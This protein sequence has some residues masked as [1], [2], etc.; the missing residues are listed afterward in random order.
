M[1]YKTF[2]LKNNPDFEYRFKGGYWQKRP[3]GSSDKWYKVSSSGQDVLN[4]SHKPKKGIKPFWYL[5]NVTKIGV[6]LILIG[7]GSYFYL[8]R[9]N[10]NLNG[11]R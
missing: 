5:S 10:N 2:L 6:G 7:V 3:I 1:I 4:E 11:L 9:S 8:K